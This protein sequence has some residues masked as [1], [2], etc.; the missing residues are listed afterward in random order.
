MEVVQPPT[1]RYVPP[2]NTRTQAID[3]YVL[4]VSVDLTGSTEFK[5]RRDKW[6]AH[7]VPFYD[8]VRTHLC[9]TG[10]NLKLLK[11]VGDEVVLYREL[12][13]GDRLPTI[14]E[15][16]WKGLEKIAVEAANN[17]KHREYS[18]YS[19]RLLGTKSTAWIAKVRNLGPLSAGDMDFVEARAGG[20]RNI[21]FSP[22]DANGNVEALDFVGRDIDAGFRHTGHTRDRVLA[23]TPELAWLVVTTDQTQQVR[24]TAKQWELGAVAKAVRIIDWQKLKGT[25]YGRPAPI[26]WLALDRKEDVAA[27]HE[28]QS[29]PT[30]KA[31]LLKLFTP[32]PAAPS[33][34][35][36]LRAFLAFQ[37]RLDELRADWQCIPG[38]P[39]FGARRTTT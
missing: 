10:P 29:D 35:E 3:P 22:T 24:G 16:V 12:E 19:S 6:H 1:N 18:A 23:L 34:E 14:V 27:A 38:V 36:Q 5:S 33:V 28:G 20:A 39:E 26:S 8:R 4:F 13:L 21:S 2:T 17:E 11:L 31:Q 37:D 25:W 15:Q 32:D 7:W 9:R 30:V